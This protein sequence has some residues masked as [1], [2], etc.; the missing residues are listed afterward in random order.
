[1]GADDKLK[2]MDELGGPSFMTTLYWLFIKGYFKTAQQM[3]VRR[4]DRQ[5]C[6]VVHSIISIWTI[7]N[8]DTVHFPPSIQ[9]WL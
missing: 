3:Q 2:T 9:L 5:I 8:P 7:V 6:A 1:M 4:V